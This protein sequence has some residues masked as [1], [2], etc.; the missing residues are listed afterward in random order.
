MHLFT[1][2]VGKCETL[3]HLAF[4][5]LSRLAEQDSV[6]ATMQEWPWS[7]DKETLGELGLAA[8]PGSAKSVILYS[9]DLKLVSYESDA[10]GR[11]TIAQF[12]M[13]SG[14]VINCI[15]LHWH[16]RHSHSEVV[17]PY[18]RGGAMAL[19]RHYLE[20]RLEKGI[21][22]VMMGDFNTTPTDGDMASPYCL[23]ALSSRHKTSGSK[24][25][26]VMGKEKRPWCLL[27]SKISR[28]IGT[29]YH[30]KN[31]VW[32]LFDHVVLSPEL[33]QNFSNGKSVPEVQVLTEIDG[34]NF[35]TKHEVPRT[36]KYS[37]DHL[38]VLCIL[39]YQ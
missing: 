11:A 19:F 3:T 23:F 36:Q 12:S 10:S 33:A 4:L 38:P 6:I 17:E 32:L 28:G 35:L 1:W 2:N 24:K 27:E 26:V 31:N 18:E 25:E 21:P 14:N 29:F 16:S 5:Y 39:H 7:V 34:N 9:T 13:P 15:G 37:S 20:E 22:A 8:V 30:K